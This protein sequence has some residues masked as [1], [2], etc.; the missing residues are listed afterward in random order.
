M[1]PIVTG[2]IGKEICRQ[3][4]A[5][6][7]KVVA[8]YFPADKD[9]AESWQAAQKEAGFDIQIAP[10]DVTDFDA[11]GAMIADIESNIGPIDI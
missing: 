10:A 5:S 11:T 3:L 4:A 2:G 6:G 1:L 7:C 9:N 8:N